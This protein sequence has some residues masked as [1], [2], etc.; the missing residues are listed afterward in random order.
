M[1]LDALQTILNPITNAHPLIGDIEATVPFIVYTAKPRPVNIK[2]GQDG[3]IYLV[4]I[5][6]AA[7]TISS[8]LTLKASVLAAILPLKG[9][10]NSTVIEGVIQTDDSGPY[11]ENENALNINDL[12]FTIFTTNE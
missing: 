3:F 10:Y 7:A 4:N 5:G 2:A 1:I 12:E 9:T 6:I 11:F 8:L